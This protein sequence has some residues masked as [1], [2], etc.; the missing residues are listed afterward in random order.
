M[1]IQISL[2]K[3]QFTV[4][5]INQLEHRMRAGEIGTRFD[6]QKAKKKIEP[7]MIQ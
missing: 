5:K 1:E 7:V 4:E 6:G 3:R 2:E